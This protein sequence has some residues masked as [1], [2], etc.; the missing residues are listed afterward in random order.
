MGFA[1]EVAKAVIPS[2]LLPAV[3]RAAAAGGLVRGAAAD[4]ANVPF[5]YPFTE[6]MKIHSPRQNYRWGTFAAALM[7]KALGY[8]R[9]SVIEFGV[10][11]GNG[12]VALERVAEEASRRSGV[13]IDV[14]GFDTGTGLP[15]PQDYR[16]LPQMWREGYYG[17]DVE[18]LKR[19]LSR[20]QLLLGPVAQ[21]VA[22][23]AES[24]P[25]PIGFVS[26][27]MDLYSSTRDAF[28]LFSGRTDLLLPRVVCYFDDI[29]GYSHSDFAGERL[30]ISEFNAAHERRKISQMYGLRKFIRGQYMWLDMMYLAHAFDHPRYCDFDGWHTLSELPLVSD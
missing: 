30:A 6:L 28:A 18:A 27:D 24:R 21:T 20:A 19:R 15:K 26:F 29:I 12:L 7:A 4:A 5:E 25:A 11:G 22:T 8:P 10:A 16:D 3:R 2:R 1:K 14:Y 23:F 17:M 9:I 13:Q